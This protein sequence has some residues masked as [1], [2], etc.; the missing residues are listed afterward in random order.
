MKSLIHNLKQF[1]VMLKPFYPNLYRLAWVMGGVLLGMLIVYLVVPIEF[2]N[3]AAPVQ[4]DETYREQWVK[5]AAAEYEITGDRSEVERKLIAAG[6]TADEVE[7]LSSDNQGTEIGSLLSQIEPIASDVSDSAQAQE[8]EFA[9]PGGFA[10]FMPA[11]VYIVVAILGILIAVGLTL[12]PDPIGMI[13]RR[14]FPSGEMTALDIEK[15]KRAQ[16]KELQA[17]RSEFEEAPVAQFMST[18]MHG[19]NFYDDSFA[20]ETED[21]KFLGECGSGI[22]DTV[23]VGDIKKVAAT[24]VWLFAQNDIT[25]LTHILMSEHAYNNEDMRNKLAVRG[26]PVLAAP[27]A[28]TVIETDSLRMQVRIVDMSYGEGGA[29]DNSFFERLTVEI[30]VWEKASV[31]VAPST[32]GGVQ[33]TPPQPVITPPPAQPQPQPQFSPPPQQAPPQP[34]PMQ[35]RPQQPPPQGPAMQPPQPGGGTMQPPPRAPQPP[36]Q[37]PTMRPPQQGGGRMQP[38]QEGGRTQPPDQPT[39]PPSPYGDTNY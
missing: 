16:A 15:Q 29:P 5:G 13:R 25:T 12:Y 23:G 18:Y 26:E 22:A 34:Q 28:I 10:N 27:G 9:E 8:E 32:P 39:N 31:G 3:N 6:V 17:Q 11:L 33:F 37:G 2:R 20:I 30:A 35:P 24:E 1:D 36:P 14:F 7:S 19:D 38:P 4:M 21:G